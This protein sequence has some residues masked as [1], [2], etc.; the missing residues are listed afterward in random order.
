MVVMKL[1][2]HV[3]QLW[4]YP[5]LRPPDTQN[6][7]GAGSMIQILSL[8]NNYDQVRIFCFATLE[9]P[10]LRSP[11]TR[12]CNGT[13]LTVQISPLINESDQVAI[14]CF[15]SFHDSTFESFES[16]VSGT[17]ISCQMSSLMMDGLDDFIIS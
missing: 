7:D 1:E 17:L 10:C 11:N 4:K 6:C 12:N 14:S 15:T 13:G 5:Y 9:S 3:S 16:R 2:F 8:I